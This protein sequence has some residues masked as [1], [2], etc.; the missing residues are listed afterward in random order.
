MKLNY[1]CIRD[2][3]LTTE[4]LTGLKDNLLF[5]CIGLYDVASQL[6][7]YDIKEIFYTVLKLDEAGYIKS[8]WLDDK[9]STNYM[10]YM[11]YDITFKGHEYLNSIRNSKVWEYI[12]KG[13]AALSMSIIP[14]LAE[15]YVL[16]CLNYP[17]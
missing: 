16:S 12:K 1:D 6:E 2:V 7:Q 15:Q 11:V 3:L 13:A 4:E 9:E 8:G 17:K 14:K 5:E 10:F